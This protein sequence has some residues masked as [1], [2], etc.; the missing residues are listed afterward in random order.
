MDKAELI[1]R[2]LATFQVE[3]QEQLRAFNRELMALEREPTGEAANASIAV[4][5]R[6]VHSLKGA[7]RSVEALR[8]SRAAHALEEL[9]SQL[10]DGRR[11]VTPELLALLFSASD[12]L[13]AAGRQLSVA[14]EARSPQAD[15][16]LDALVAQVAALQPPAAA[17]SSPAA[18]AA[19]SAPTPLDLSLPP[20]ATSLPGPEPA[21]SQR[22][23][24]RPAALEELSPEVSAQL[25]ALAAIAPPPHA[26]PREG[27]SSLRVSA[28]P[29]AE[30][31]E[32][33]TFVRVPIRRLDTLLAQAGELAV[34]RRRLEIRRDELEALHESA[35]HLRS[36]FRFL[37]ASAKVQPRVNGGP[38]SS[39]TAAGPGALGPGSPARSSALSPGAA[40]LTGPQSL[41]L[42]ELES[43]K[44]Q[45][46][47]SQADSALERL[48]SELSRVSLSLREDVAS[49]DRAASPLEAQVHRA[50]MLRFGE[51]CEGLS[52]TVRDLSQAQGKQVELQVQ[53]SEVELDRAIIDSARVALL[54][55]VRNAI[56]H[57]V[58]TPE[59]RVRCGKPPRARLS[60]HAAASG[61][62]VRIQVRDDGRGIDPV[63]LR[64]E[65]QRRGLTPPTEER[66]LLRVIFAPG[67]ST[68]Q[69]ITEVSGRGVGLDV[70][71]NLVYELGGEVELIS[72][73]GAG[74][75][76]SLQLP[77]T[78]STLRALLVDVG[79][80]VLALPSRSVQRLLRVSPEEIAQS[81]GRQ[82]LKVA[83]GAPLPLAALREVLELGGDAAERAPGE[84]LSVVL[85]ASES[86]VAALVVDG[87]QNE[88]DL[89][90]KPLG[91]RVRKLRKVSGAALLPTGEIALVLKPNELV[92]RV[93][94]GSGVGPVLSA[95]EGAVQTKKKRV[96]LAD[97]SVTTRTLE[98]SILEAA[99]YEVVAAVD[100]EQAFAL[101]QERGADVVVSDVEMP[102]M[103]GFA[104]TLAIRASPRFR[105]LPVVLLTA[106]SAESD[107]ARGMQCGADAY[108]VKRAF[109]Q[110]LLIETLR[111][112]T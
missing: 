32:S 63:A 90:Q 84:R 69:L 9:L 104:L 6:S 51:A 30:A 41:G 65:V 28:A 59:E 80:Q 56:D 36:T 20:T 21:V 23:T 66:D 106:L 100:G 16:A 89:V 82:V 38:V 92:Q 35:A 54:H 108:L 26:A 47:L 91:R 11:S 98:R 18:P 102:K 39:G 49:L 10:R 74:C 111:Q 112:L 13:E 43:G 78:A 48:E 103:D 44:L 22:P 72:E 87:W 55:L 31:A 37:R 95:R 46:V 97:D 25:A 77:A 5:F 68:A 67:F 17:P 79:S 71:Q 29:S 40:P 70:V 96:L 81:Q 2:L 83:E 4:L 86:R 3:L 60:I 14:P 85:L 1:R 50:R 93:Y 12:V 101:L 27:V 24:T 64:E 61:E 76:F 57:G 73:P 52:R 88:Q 33:R 19:R 107:K 109:D 62:Q 58:E 7:A 34:A 94:A 105:N 53:G 15:A 42:I 110:Q 45:R 8:L 75:T 99:G